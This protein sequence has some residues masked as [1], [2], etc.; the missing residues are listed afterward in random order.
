MFECKKSRVNSRALCH[1][2]EKT[3]KIQWLALVYGSQNMRERNSG[4]CVPRGNEASPK[5]SEN[6]SSFA[7]TPAGAPMK[8]TLVLSQLSSSPPLHYLDA[9][10][11]NNFNL[12]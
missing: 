5:L 3:E 1:T 9:G 8:D 12:C 10:I 7:T 6:S 2:P 11:R 4:T